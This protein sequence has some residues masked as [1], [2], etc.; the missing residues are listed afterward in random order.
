MGN[1]N[2]FIKVEKTVFLNIAITKLA[3][4]FLA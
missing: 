1:I 2:T 4:C 3:I